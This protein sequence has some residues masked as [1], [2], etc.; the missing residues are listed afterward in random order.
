ML[1]SFFLATLAPVR[2]NHFSGT[3]GESIESWILEAQGVL[4]HKI[5]SLIYSKVPMTLLRNHLIGKARDWY[6]QQEPK[7]VDSPEK[8]YKALRLRFGTNLDPSELE[9]EFTQI[10]QHQRK[11][12]LNMKK[13]L[14]KQVQDGG[15]TF[16][17]ENLSLPS[18]L[19]FAI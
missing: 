8:L 2:L 9:K 17:K 18:K 4:N 10:Q 3:V 16:L 11:E 13:E 19:D 1:S 15:Q 14:D 6:Y 5:Q 7:D 12:P